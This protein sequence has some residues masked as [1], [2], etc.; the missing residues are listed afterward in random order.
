MTQ[1]DILVKVLQDNLGDNYEVDAFRSA[2]VDETPTVVIENLLINTEQRM[3][4]TINRK[5]V[6]VI[7]RTS[8]GQ[9]VSIA[10]V[11]SSSFTWS[12]EVA[13][14]VDAG[15]IDTDIEM[16]QNTFN[17]KIIPVIIGDK[18]YILK[19]TFIMPA[20][21]TAATISGTTYIQVIMG[22]NATITD[23]SE[24]ADYYSLSING[25]VVDNVISNQ[26]AF[27]PQGEAYESNSGT[28]E[29]TDAVQTF[30]NAVSYKLHALKG[31]P[32]TK[33][34]VQKS[35]SGDKE[36]FDISVL[37]TANTDGEST[38]EVLARYPNAILNGCTVSGDIGSYL[39][40]DISFLKG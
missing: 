37:Y 33:K 17:G 19:M 25:A 6:R 18:Q 15:Y 34:L 3:L 35:L 14:P 22:G 9:F 30:N 31:D 7:V 12:A 29:Q 20:K 21:F 39:M 26:Y 11:E 16:F 27:N 2:I 4:D 10:G 40:I 23:K 5:K 13:A 32:L 1:A 28:G 38:S 24:L 8:Q 36:E